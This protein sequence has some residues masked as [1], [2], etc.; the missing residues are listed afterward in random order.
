MGHGGDREFGQIPILSFQRSIAM[1]PDVPPL[2]VPATFRP[3]RPP[4]PDALTPAERARRTRQKRKDA[5]LVAVTCHL[6]PS[7]RAYLAALSAIHGCT[8]SEAVGLALEA[9]IRQGMNAFCATTAS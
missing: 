2:L 9:A 6:S 8:I 7:Q 3:G 5:G 4:K 1:N